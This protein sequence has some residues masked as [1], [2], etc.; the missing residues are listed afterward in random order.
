MGVNG[1]TQFNVTGIPNATQYYWFIT[2]NNS[3]CPSGNSVKP[4]FQTGNGYSSTLTS[5]YP[6]ATV[7]WGTCPGSYTV[8]MLASNGCGSSAVPFKNV[9]VYGYNDSPCPDGP[10][11]KKGFTLSQNPTKGGTIIINKIPPS[12]PCDVPDPN[13]NNISNTVTIFD[14]NGNVF[15]QDTFTKSVIALDKLEMKSGK[16]IVRVT[17]ALGNR[18]SK[19]LLVE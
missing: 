5:S 16:Y 18:E 7:Y 13:R 4:K 19:I 9:T 3:K 12:Q 15:F 2:E 14:F 17:D 10:V 8:N 1:S 11:G 6:Y